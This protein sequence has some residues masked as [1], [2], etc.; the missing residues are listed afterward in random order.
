MTIFSFSFFTGFK[1]FFNENKNISKGRNKAFF[2]FS[3]LPV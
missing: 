2:L 1:K 3:F